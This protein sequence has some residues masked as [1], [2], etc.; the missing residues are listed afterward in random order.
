MVGSQPHMLYVKAMAIFKR[1][2]LK[3][4]IYKLG[5]HP[6]GGS[7]VHFEIPPNILQQYFSFM[8]PRKQWW[9]TIS[10]FSSIRRFGL[11]GIDLGVLIF[12]FKV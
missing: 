6:K 8:S 1:S 3:G 7:R 12:R 4:M 11:I 10:Y 9:I 5:P 2:V